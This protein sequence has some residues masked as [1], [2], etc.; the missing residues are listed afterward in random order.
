[1]L[2][3]AGSPRNLGLDVLPAAITANQRMDDPQEPLPYSE[4]VAIAKSVE[5]YR[6]LWRLPDMSPQAVSERQRERQRRSAESRRAKNAER[7]L[8][9]VEMHNDGLSERKIASEVGLSKS[10]ISKVIHRDTRSLPT[11]GDPPEGGINCV[12]Q[13]GQFKDERKRSSK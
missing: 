4:V 9:I 10:M 7:D 5:R 6:T 1:M 8:R 11:A 3:W 2:R 13:S 12:W